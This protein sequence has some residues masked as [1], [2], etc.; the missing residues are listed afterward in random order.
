MHELKRR[1]LET[2]AQMTRILQAMDTVQQGVSGLHP[3]EN[4]GEED[5][6]PPAQVRSWDPDSCFHDQTQ[7]TQPSVSCFRQ[8]G[9]VVFCGVEHWSSGTGF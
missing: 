5:G 3:P 9:Y 4:N 1:L 6:A 8:C 2:E 7:T